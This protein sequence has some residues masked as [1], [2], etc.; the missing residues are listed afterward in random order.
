MNSERPIVRQLRL[1]FAVHGPVLLLLLGIALQA[2]GGRTVEV[3]FLSANTKEDWIDEVTAAFNASQFTVASGKPIVVTVTHGNSGGTQQ[4]ILDGEVKPTV[5]SPGDQSW[6]DGANQVWTER[7]GRSLV[8]ETCSPTVYAPIGFGMWRPMAEALGWPEEPISWETIVSLASDP[9]GWASYG[10]PEWGQFKFGHTHPDYSNSG[11]LM[12]TALA[13]DTLGIADGLTPEQVKS[14]P[15]VEAMQDVELHTYH[16]G[17]QSRNLAN[18]MVRKGPSYLHAINI[19]EAEVLRT[20]KEYGEEMV[21]PLVFIFPS[22][23]T[24]WTEQPFC[25]LDTDW[26]SEEEQK[27]AELYRQYLLAPDQQAMAID[28]G[29][30][31]VDS[32]IPL[33]QPF[34][35]ADGTD[36]SVTPDTVRA[37][38]SPSAETAEAIKDVFHQ[39][40]KRSTIVVVLDRSTSMRVENKL[41][42]AKKAT[43]SFLGRLDEDDQVT[44]YAFADQIVELEPAGRAGDVVEPLSQ[45]VLELSAQPS[46][47][48]YDAVCQTIADMDVLRESDRSAGEQRLYGIVVLSDGDDTASARTETTMNM[49]LPTGEDV[50]GVKIFTIAYGSG[51]NLAVLERIAEQTNGRMFEGDPDTIEDVYLA[52]SAEQ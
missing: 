25:I 8:S 35:L 1:R 3:S 19:T 17:R 18:L 23:G 20:N 43:A 32:S 48:L 6:V 4:D 46:T 47:R 41:R 2:C 15:V 24:F 13:Y 28:N 12:M 33:H 27:A 7:H 10:H 9:D 14:Q 29:L 22:E 52:I 40:K 34:T 45:T 37:L 38:K 36:P 42:N 31:P 5:W 16:Y 44:V 11:L 50:E 51:A 49:C 26:V 30:R 39:T 21:F